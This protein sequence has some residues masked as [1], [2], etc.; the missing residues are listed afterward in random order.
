MAALSKWRAMAGHGGPRARGFGDL[1]RA[2]AFGGMTV[3]S[4]RVL[5]TLT[6][7]DLTR[8]VVNA[9]RQAPHA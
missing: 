1:L 9:A 3:W 8:E 4:R 6:R 7:I 2:G 5:S